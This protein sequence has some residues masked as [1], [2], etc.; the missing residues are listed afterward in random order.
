MNQPNELP[1]ARKKGK[2]KFRWKDLSP[3]LPVNASSSPK[4]NATMAPVQ[5][6]NSAPSPNLP[7]TARVCAMDIALKCG[8]IIQRKEVHA[9]F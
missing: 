4:I 9:L 3:I 1:P 2:K 7:S 8:R 5:I 6:S